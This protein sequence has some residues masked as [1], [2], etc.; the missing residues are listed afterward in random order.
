MTSRLVVNL[1]LLAAFATAAHAAERPGDATPAQQGGPK[2]QLVVLGGSDASQ[3]LPYATVKPVAAG[4]GPDG[5]VIFLLVQSLTTGQRPPNS[6]FEPGSPVYAEPGSC[7]TSETAD[8]CSPKT[9]TLVYDGGSDRWVDSGLACEPDLL[10]PGPTISFELT[11]TIGT[12]A[13]LISDSLCI[14]QAKGAYLP[15]PLAGRLSGLCNALPG[16]WCRSK[17]HGEKCAPDVGHSKPCTWYK[18][19][20]TTGFQAL[21]SS[22]R[23]P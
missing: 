11:N 4:V 7:D 15:L 5:P 2:A 19:C 13:T 22:S 8:C 9:G 14:A 10:S 16:N 1:L 18:Q 23:C 21:P 3:L 20:P 6:L 17:S 12:L